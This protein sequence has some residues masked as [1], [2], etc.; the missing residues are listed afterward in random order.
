MSRPAAALLAALACL[1]ISGVYEMSTD[2][3]D[4]VLTV[5]QEGCAK[6]E[7]VLDYGNGYAF[8]ETMLFD[9]VARPVRD[10][11]G[12]LFLKSWRFEGGRIRMDAD[13][14]FHRTGARM[15]ETTYF[16]LNASRDLVEERTHYDRDR[17][18]NGRHSV[19]YRRR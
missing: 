4:A 2:D 18:E 14:K 13:Y 17:R 10:D 5:R 7:L 19:Y 11:D 16:R 6:A 1:D 3:A 12:A 9:G 8:P 15:F